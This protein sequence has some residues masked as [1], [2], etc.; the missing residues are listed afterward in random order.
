MRVPRKGLFSI[1][2]CLRVMH[3]APLAVQAWKQL[4]KHFVKDDEL[5]EEGGGL[6]AIQRRVDPELAGL[7]VV[8]AEGNAP[9]AP[10]L[11]QLSRPQC[12]A[13]PRRY[14]DPVPS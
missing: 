4:V 5:H 7:R 14:T 9:P 2:K 11:G 8:N 1:P 6:T 10:A 12:C 13:N 3:S